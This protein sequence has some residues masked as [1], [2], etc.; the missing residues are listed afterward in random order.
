MKINQRRYIGCKTK[1]LNE[2]VSYPMSLYPDIFT[3]SKSMLDVFAGTG[4]VT[5]KYIDVLNDSDKT[6]MVNDF[7]YSNRICYE[8]FFGKGKYSMNKLHKLVDNLI[9]SRQSNVCQEYYGDRY[10]SINDSRAIGNYRSAIEQWLDEKLINKKE[11]AVLIASLCY[12]ADKI[13]NTVGHYDAYISNKKPSDRFTFEFIEPIDDIKPNIKIYQEDS[14]S[15]VR[16]LGADIMFI[17]PP[18]NSRQYSRFYHVLEQIAGN[19]QLP[20]MKNNMAK[21]PECRD[22]SD[23]CKVNA[24]EVFDDL[25]QHLKCRYIIT[26]YNNTYNARS[27][28]SN[29]KITIDQLVSSLEKRGH[30]DYVPVGFPYFSAG[31]TSLDEHCEYIFVT[32]VEE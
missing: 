17:D 24:P 11:Y 2:L 7:L 1:L 26:T 25:I 18:Y 28:S 4:V 12:S 14:N 3:N 20:L 30:T 6:I 22:M 10:F 16:R 15:L 31:K 32:K 21:K 19:F 29:N 9:M 8:A 27:S 23:Y 5:A 13:A